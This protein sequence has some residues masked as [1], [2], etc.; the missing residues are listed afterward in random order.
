M[1][2]ITYKDESGSEISR[3]TK[4]KSV[5]RLCA[6]KF[7]KKGVDYNIINET[8]NKITKI[9]HNK[10]LAIDCFVDEFIDI[11][12]KLKK[13]ESKSW[14]FSYEKLRSVDLSNLE[15]LV[16]CSKSEVDCIGKMLNIKKT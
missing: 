3:T 10:I 2:I 8:S 7:R 16:K 15:N 5:A 4:D 13:I 9:D 1:Y 6:I 11:A 12:S 14:Q